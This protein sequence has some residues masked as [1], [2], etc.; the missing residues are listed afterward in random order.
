MSAAGGGRGG[1]T[2]VSTEGSAMR[3]PMTAKV[4][5]EDLGTQI[6]EGVMARGTR[7]TTTIEAGAI[8]NTQ[9][10]DPCRSS[11]SPRTSRCW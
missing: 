3:V 8:G 7:S 2:V 11:G 5:K 6:V 4:N 1:A 10:I 9:P